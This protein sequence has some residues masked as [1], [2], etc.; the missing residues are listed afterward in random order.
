MNSIN[1]N[2]GFVKICNEHIPCPPFHLRT[3][4][5][6]NDSGKLHP[7]YSLKLSSMAWTEKKKT[8]IENPCL[9]EELCYIYSMVQFTVPWLSA[10]KPM[11][12]LTW[13]FYMIKIGQSGCSLIQGLLLATGRSSYFGTY[14]LVVT[15]FLL[16]VN[17][18]FYD[19]QF[20]LGKFYQLVAGVSCQNSPRKKQQA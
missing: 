13:I 11:F 7:L 6:A 18:T 19:Y 8:Y 15:L 10:N 12:G 4:G 17:C 16:L 14:A 2:A 20:F 9:S 3:K 1:N 5:C